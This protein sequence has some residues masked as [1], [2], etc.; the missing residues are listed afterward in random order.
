MLEG[1]N[2]KITI[3]PISCIVEKATSFFKSICTHIFNEASKILITATVRKIQVRLSEK[4]KINLYKPK[5]ADL[6]SIPLKNIEN[7]VFAS[8]CVLLNQK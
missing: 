7:P 2:N 1:Y 4:R 8:T 6:T 3:K 5:I